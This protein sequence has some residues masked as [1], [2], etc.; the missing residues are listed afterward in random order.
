MQTPFFF[1]SSIEYSE[2]YQSINERESANKM[3]ARSMAMA[4]GHSV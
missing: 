3:D 1:R 2:T 4:L